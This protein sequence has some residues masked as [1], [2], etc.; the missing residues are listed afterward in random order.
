LNG[1]YIAARSFPGA[2][3]KLRTVAK[4]GDLNISSAGFINRSGPLER[5]AYHVVLYRG[6]V[7]FGDRGSG[8]RPLGI[9]EEKSICKSGF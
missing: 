3:A 8:S 5:A 7:R 2:S 1:R 9:R 4:E 6:R